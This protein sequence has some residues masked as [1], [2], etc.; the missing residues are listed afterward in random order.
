M[1]IRLDGSLASYKPEPPRP[2]VSPQGHFNLSLELI[3]TTNICC[4]CCVS[5]QAS[6]V[7]QFAANI[8]FKSKQNTWEIE[9]GGSI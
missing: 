6:I 3:L 1:M 9:K 5:V 2:L 7:R 4:L 8:H